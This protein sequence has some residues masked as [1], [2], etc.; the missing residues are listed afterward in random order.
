[1]GDGGDHLKLLRLL[2]GG[3]M[4]RSGAEQAHIIGLLQAGHQ[5]GDEPLWR[6]CHGGAVF[7]GNDDEKAAADTQDPVLL[8]EPRRQVMVRMFLMLSI[9]CPRYSLDGGSDNFPSI[10]FRTSSSDRVLP[11]MA[12]VTKAPLAVNPETVSLLPP[13]S[14]RIAYSL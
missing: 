2:M 6:Q 1:L 5:I 3:A 4:K 14:I 8:R 10:L 13:S 11:S 7:Q 12:V 9:S